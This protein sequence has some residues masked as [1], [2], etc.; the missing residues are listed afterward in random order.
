MILVLEI[1]MAVMGIKALVTGKLQMTGSKVVAGGAARVLG[2]ILLT[3]VPIAAVAYIVIVFA[4]APANPE[5]YAE[6]N[7]LMLALVEAAVVI[8]ILI[9]VAVLCSM[10][11]KSPAEKWQSR[12]DNDF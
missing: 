2:V 5:Q 10:L 11:G 6:D 12:D 8:G 1:V 4:A 9:L 7:K 3:P